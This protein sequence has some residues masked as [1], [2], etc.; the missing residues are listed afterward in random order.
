MTKEEALA[1]LYAARYHERRISFLD[2][3]E[4][5]RDFVYSKLDDL[6]KERA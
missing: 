3:P 2:I 6:D 5:L 1:I 4:N